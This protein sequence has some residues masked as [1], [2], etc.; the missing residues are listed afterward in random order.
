MDRA[1]LR[2]DQASRVHPLD[3]GNQDAIERADL[4][5]TEAINVGQE[6]VRHLLQNSRVPLRRRIDCGAGEFRDRIR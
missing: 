2:W 4:G 5:F 3:Q 6:E 1:S